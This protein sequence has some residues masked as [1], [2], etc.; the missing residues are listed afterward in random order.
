VAKDIEVAIIRTHFE[1]CVVRSI[2]VIQNL[3]HLV[4]VLAESETNRILVGLAAGIALYPHLLIFIWQL[5]EP[6][7]YG[8]DR[9]NGVTE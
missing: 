8:L 6:L 1:I 7:S 5:G 4:F 3:F 9:R 2:P